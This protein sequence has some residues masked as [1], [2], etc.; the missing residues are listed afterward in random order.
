[1][2]EGRW[3]RRCAR[4][5]LKTEQRTERH[6][7]GSTGRQASSEARC[8]TRERGRAVEVTVVDHLASAP[9]GSSRHRPGRMTE[10]RRVAC[11]VT[12]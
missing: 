4:R 1:V 8:S 9:T 3:R 7:T 2:L 10:R 5:T 12:P 11:A 6:T